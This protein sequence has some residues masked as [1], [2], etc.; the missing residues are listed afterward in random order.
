M[1]DPE[2]FVAEVLTSA[3]VEAE[4]ER[5][6]A[7]YA[8]ERIAEKVARLREPKQRDGL[9][10]LNETLLQ[11]DVPPGVRLHLISAVAHLGRIAGE[12]LQERRM[13]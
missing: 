1:T 11:H 8:D 5:V 9:Q 2:R 3:G 13:R 12:T 6:S 4:T 10:A 7:A